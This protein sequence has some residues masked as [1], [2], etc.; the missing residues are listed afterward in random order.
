MIIS[1][2][3]NTR[4]REIVKRFIQATLADWI[5]VCISTSGKHFSESDHINLKL[6]FRESRGANLEFQMGSLGTHA[7]IGSK[8]GF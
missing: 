1:I 5:K 6:L 7:A 2:K 8:L 4:K 3:R